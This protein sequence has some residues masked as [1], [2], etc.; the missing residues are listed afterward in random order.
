MRKLL[1]KNE[2]GFTLIELL[3]VIVILGI[4]MIV[5]IPMVTRYIEQARRDTFV[6]TAKAYINAA[7]Y[8]YL[9]DDYSGIQS[10][11]ANLDPSSESCSQSID[12]KIPIGEID[13]DNAGKSSFGGNLSG[14]VFIKATE[15]TDASGGTIYRYKYYISLKDDDKGWKITGEEE[16]DLSRD[17][18]SRKN[19]DFTSATKILCKSNIQVDQNA[20]KK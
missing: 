20:N 6:D 17:S 7:R 14:H 11:A 10:G 13:V 19:S 4:L 15:G 18:V 8:S 12:A 9:N 16:K 3:A 5:A 2:K 1:I